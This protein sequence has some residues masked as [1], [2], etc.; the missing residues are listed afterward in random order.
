MFR[1]LI[2]ASMPLALAACTAAGGPADFMSDNS[3]QTPA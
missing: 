1:I 3:P 2:A